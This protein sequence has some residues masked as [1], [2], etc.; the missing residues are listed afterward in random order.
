MTSIS[1]KQFDEALGFSVFSSELDLEARFQ[2]KGESVVDWN[3]NKDPEIIQREKDR[4][5]RDNLQ[6]QHGDTGEFYDQVSDLKESSR[7]LKK[8]FLLVLSRS[9]APSQTVPGF[10]RDAYCP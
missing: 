4:I 9:Q 8:S 10:S 5:D 2:H 6:S 3:Y 1:E 7:F